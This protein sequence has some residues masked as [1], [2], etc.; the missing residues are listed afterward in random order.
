MS[1]APSMPVFTDALLGDTMHLSA[2]E[3]GSYCLLLFA[4]WRNNGRALRDDDAQLARICRCSVRRWR[5]RLRVVL[6]EFF[7]ISDGTW[8][9]KRLE[10][11]WQY[12][13]KVA[14]ISRKNGAR[15]GRPKVLQNNETQN[16]A[17]SSQVSQE[18]SPHTHTHLSKNNLYNLP[19]ASSSV[20]SSSV[21]RSEEGWQA[22]RRAEGKNFKICEEWIG[23]AETMRRDEGLYP[24]DLVEEARKC[25][26]RWEYDPPRNARAAWLGYAKRAKGKARPDRPD[27][28]PPPLHEIWPDLKGRA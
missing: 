6:V 25:A 11:E 12:C 5:A 26:E 7:D 2:E 14:A 3:F 22:G 17:G 16:P 4:T 8:R 19:P 15:G 1:Q 28:P 20:G 13:A 18:Q 27:G 23:A 9:Q 24:A 10:K 21:P